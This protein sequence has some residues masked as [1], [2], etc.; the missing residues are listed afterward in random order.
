MPAPCNE[1]RPKKYLFPDIPIIQTWRNLRNLSLAIPPGRF[2]VQC[3]PRGISIYSTGAKHIS[4]GFCHYKKS[5]FKKL[6]NEV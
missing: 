4:L 3:L 5:F 1:I 6:T 2:T